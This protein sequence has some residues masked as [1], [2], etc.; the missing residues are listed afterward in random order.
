MKKLIVVDESR[1][2]VNPFTASLKIP[3]SKIVDGKQWRSD[4]DGVMHPVEYLWER[5]QSTKIYYSKDC[6]KLVYNLSPA[7]KS[8]YLFV[9]YNLETNQDHIVLNKD[10]Y[11]K[12]ND[13]KSINTYKKAVSEL[14]DN[15]FIT[16]SSAYPKDVFWIN[17]NLFF[18]GNRI[19]KYPDNLEIKNDLTK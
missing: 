14:W 2:K 3:V 19:S 16:P 11:M 17:P 5:E 12:K 15:G 10:N 1:M 4:L 7:G 8:L 6:R 13:I 9:L 18:N